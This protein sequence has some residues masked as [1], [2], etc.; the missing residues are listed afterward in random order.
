M[1]GICKV[2][3]EVVNGAGAGVH[4]LEPCTHHG[5]HGQPPILD[6][7][8]PQLLELGRVAGAPSEGVEPEPAGVPDVGAGELVVGE[9]GVGVDGAGLED[10][11]PPPPLRPS[12]ED[13]LNHEE[14]G[15]VG[16][17]F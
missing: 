10:V 5:Q 7:L 12:D 3:K 2:S 11:G 1:A 4:S 16:E 6:L 17:V 8:G 14:G 9:D 15:G 13:E